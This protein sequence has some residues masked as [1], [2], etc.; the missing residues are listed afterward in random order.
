[1]D[2]EIVAA[3]CE[4]P[5]RVEIA[6]GVLQPLAAL[7]DALTPRP[8]TPTVPGTSALATPAAP[9]GCIRASANAEAFRKRFFPQAT[10]AD[11]NDWRWQLANRIKDAATLRRMIDLSDDERTGLYA[12][13]G[14]FPF[15]VTPYYASLIDPHNPAQPLRRCVIPT[16]HE[17]VMGPGEAA[18]PLGEEHD[19]PAP[20]LVHRYPDRVLFLTTH[21]CSTYCRYCTRS[22]LVGGVTQDPS[23]RSRWEQ[24][25]DYIRRTPQVRDVLLSG[26]DPLVMADETLDWLLSQIRRIPHVEIVR[27]GTK[28]PMVLPQRITRSL[29]KMLR[30]YHPL[31]I[32]VHCTHAQEL[33]LE[34]REAFTRLADAGIPL[35]SQTVLLQG[36]NDSPEALKALYHGLL[37]VRVRPYYLYQCDP[38]MGTAHFRTT[39]ADGLRIMQGLRGH[40]SGYAVPTYVIDAPG[41]GGKV[42]IYADTMV[43]RDGDDL[44]LRNY[45]GGIYRYPDPA[46]GCGCAAPLPEHA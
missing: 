14:A 22:R 21:A 28:T 2:K 32:S 17:R 18:D 16:G 12:G 25:I 26:G 5:S 24:A 13:E 41:G 39:V 20:G 42:P 10:R 6:S 44:L 7:R 3:D 9:K 31:F 40:T 37:R 30:K 4:P 36:V 19:S 15:A 34:S 43:G 1:M 35:G 8:A 46:N 11:W 29:V 45:E 23:M 38:V 27:I 33:T